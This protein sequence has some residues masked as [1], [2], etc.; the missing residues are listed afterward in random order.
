M[1]SLLFNSRLCPDLCFFQ[2]KTDFPCAEIMNQETGFENL[3][4]RIISTNL[5][6]DS[7]SRSNRYL[8]SPNQIRS[9]DN[10]Y[11]ILA[12]GCEAHW[13]VVERILFVYSKLN[14]GQGYVQGMNEIIGPIYYTFATDPN[15][16]WR[17]ED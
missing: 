8:R 12:D 11:E 13:E 6:V 4:K 14:S 17:G 5:K 3:H 7:Q 15:I 9:G 1:K 16:E 10:E 2:R